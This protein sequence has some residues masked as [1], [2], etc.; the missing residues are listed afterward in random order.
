MSSPDDAS[1]DPDALHTALEACCD[2]LVTLTSIDRG[3]ERDDRS[4]AHLARASRSLVD[5]IA[6]LRLARTGEPSIVSLGFV[7]EADAPDPAR[8]Q[9]AGRQ[10]SPR[11]TA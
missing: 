3:A 10:V 2:L 1:L 4:S 8:E 11:R 7:L 6:E 9:S 5:V